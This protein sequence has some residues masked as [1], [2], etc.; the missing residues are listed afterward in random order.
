M[1]SNP[2]VTDLI[3]L[4]NQVCALKEVGV[5]IIHEECVTDLSWVWRNADTGKVFDTVKLSRVRAIIPLQK[6]DPRIKYLVGFAVS[7]KCF[8]ARDA[9]NKLNNLKAFW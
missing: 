4:M 2:I 6:T 5:N 9:I 8:E 3:T 1:I 7:G